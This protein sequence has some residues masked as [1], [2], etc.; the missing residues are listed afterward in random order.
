MNVA[1]AAVVP[2]VVAKPVL[3]K[4]DVSLVGAFAPN[5]AS[6]VASRYVVATLSLSVVSSCSCDAF[7]AVRYTLRAVVVG[8]PGMME[9][10]C[11]FNAVAVLDDGA[12]APSEAFAAVS[13]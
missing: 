11:T 10:S 8:G 12:A 7:A 9:D 1:P 2:D 4:P 6:A 3:D 5:P 13:V